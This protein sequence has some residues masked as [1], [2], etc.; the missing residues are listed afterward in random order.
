MR[1]FALA[2]L[3]VLAA[4]QHPPVPAGPDTCEV[5]T[6]QRGF[7]VCMQTL[8]TRAEWESVATDA[9]VI[10][11]DRVT[12]YLIPVD[13]E[14]VVPTVFVNANHYA[15]H[16]DFLRDAFPDS[17]ANLL[18]AQYVAMIVDRAQR[19]YF[20]GE[21]SEFIEADGTRRFGFIVWDDPAVEA[22]T[23]T[24]EEVLTV[25]TE[26]QARFRL[27]ALMFVPN[28]THQR[29][30]ASTWADAP[31]LIRGEDN[32]AYEAYNPGVAYGTVRLVPL[33]EL[34]DATAEARFGW[35][36]I[37]VLDEAPFDVE[38][39][40]SATV[41]GTRQGALSHLN[42]RAAA[43]GTPNCYLEAPFDALAAWEGT[44]VRF[45]CGEDIWSIAAATTAEAEDWWDTLRPDPV[46][47]SPPDLS[48]IEAV[49]L[50]DVPTDDAA[51]RDV[52]LSR[53]G[54]K[55]ANLAAL[56]QRI[57][58]AW[59]LDGLVIPFAWYDTFIETNTWELDGETLTF[60]ATLDRWLH[61]DTFLSDG[62][63]RA[64]RLDALRSAMLAAP[65][66]PLAIEALSA[67]ILTTWGDDTTMVRLRSSSN[68]EDGLAFSG[69]GLYDSESGC[70]ADELDGDAD[71]PSLCDTDKSRERP[72]SDA[73]RIVWASLWTVG[74][75][76][77]RAWYG[78]DQSLVSMAVL[79]N[80]QSEDEQANIVGFTG[81]PMAD[82]P[83]W[84]V[85]SQ[86]GDLDVVSADPGV[87]PEQVL[88]TLEGGEVTGIDRVSASSEGDLVLDDARLSELGG[89]LWDVSQVFPVD[90]VPPEG[91]AVLLDTEC[92][93]LED[94][95][96]IIKQVRPF[97]RD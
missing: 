95:R 48:V 91:T 10:D 96:L 78:L 93:I 31:F 46:D 34:A 1:G 26:L 4:C 97:L 59:Q 43:R 86:L 52:A 44:L 11:Q 72:L 29:D 14:Q 8:G 17:F 6:D 51:E 74:A 7:L 19:R 12:K 88:L 13:D 25:W 77:E 2:G 90:D 24:Y 81:N 38:R 83:R 42:V 40:V 22:Q 60:A 75:Y 94:G 49:N 56:Y 33:A 76:E 53:Y 58:P 5:L 30:A 55:G 37:L 9:A 20:G 39:V 82:D 54:A 15:L 41:T 65:V 80:T 70:L 32:I 47:I 18:W 16:Y 89:L 64:E 50:L 69:A 84:L 36:D 45:E 67:A 57:D 68:A 79:V 28:S 23:I 3:L 85:E 21:V 61:D 62:A 35:Q 27:G 66:D 73:L 63:V 87:W 92:K 71:G